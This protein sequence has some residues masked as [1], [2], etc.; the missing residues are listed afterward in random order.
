MQLPLTSVRMR[1]S[2]A[3]T[4][5]F[6]FQSSPPVAAMSFAC[7]VEPDQVRC[8]CFNAGAGAQQLLADVSSSR[9]RD[10]AVSCRKLCAGVGLHMQD[11]IVLQLW[12][13]RI[14]MHSARPQ[15]Q[16]SGSNL[17]DCATERGS[18]AVLISAPSCE[19]QQSYTVHGQW[20]Q[21]IP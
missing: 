19:C 7:L 17:P 14:R 1:V 13:L 4:F 9:E 8:C 5:S 3:G 18:W 2:L 10:L 20:R 11:Q 12:Y 16:Q 6:A 15:P 21:N